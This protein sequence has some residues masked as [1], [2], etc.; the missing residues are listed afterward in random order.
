MTCDFVG[1]RAKDCCEGLCLCQALGRTKAHLTHAEEKTLEDACTLWDSNFEW[2]NILDSDAG[3][4]NLAEVW[5]DGERFL[6]EEAMHEELA[7]GED[8]PYCGAFPDMC[9][10]N[11]ERLGSLTPE[12]KEMLVKIVHMGT[13][14]I[15]ARTPI[16]DAWI[17]PK[18]TNIVKAHGG[19]GSSINSKIVKSD[20]EKN[21]AFP[22]KVVYLEPSSNAPITVDVDVAKS[23]SHKG[24][25][26]H[27]GVRNDTGEKVWIDKFYTNIVFSRPG[28][29]FKMRLIKNE[30][31]G[32]F[33]WKTTFIWTEETVPQSRDFAP[34]KIGSLDTS[35]PNYFIAQLGRNSW[36][37]PET[38]GRSTE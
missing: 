25:K 20:V 30:R 29:T 33:P 15:H 6:Q 8:V 19:V 38:W 26:I 12:P 5:S 1:P 16:G 34:P 4:V 10:E 21:A 31:E 17:N 28:N 18:L 9:D 2:D 11:G 35:D 3:D 22:F 7:I 27:G 37:G 23:R 24:A 36:C 14:Y 32:K 13:K